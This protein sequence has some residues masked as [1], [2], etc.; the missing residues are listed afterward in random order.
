[1]CLSFYWFFSVLLLVKPKKLYINF[2][3]VKVKYVLNKQKCIKCINV[4]KMF[5]LTKNSFLSA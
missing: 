5:V 4:N 2:F 3:K 1:M